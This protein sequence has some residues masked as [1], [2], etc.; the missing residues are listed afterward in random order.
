MGLR[1]MSKPRIHYEDC[2]SGMQKR[3]DD[4]SVDL[5][6]ADPPFGIGFNPKNKG[7]YKR[8][9]KFVVGG[10]QEAPDDYYKFTMEWIREATRVLK[11]SGSIYI[12][13]SWNNLL[14]VLAAADNYDLVPR[15]HL[16]WRRTFAPYKRWGWVTAHYHILYYTKY[17]GK[18]GKNQEHTFNKILIKHPSKDKMY[19]Y[20]EDVLFHKTQYMPGELKNGT[21]L[22]LDQVHLLIKTSTNDGDVVLD[23]FLGNG[24]ALKASLNLNRDFIGFEINL[25]CKPIIDRVLKWG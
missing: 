14:D 22:P 19:H 3:V 16:I 13:S 15:G 25:E 1:M 20:P 12:Y 7:N 21:K 23:P 11:E 24:T 2:I 17:E 18:D 5:I 6:I 8:K 4:E 10:Y 9:S